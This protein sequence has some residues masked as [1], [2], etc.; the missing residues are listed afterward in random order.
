M[1]EL[2]II[3][4]IIGAGF[5]SGKEIYLFFYRFG[6]SGLMGIFVCA[7]LFSYL[8]Y[9]TL[10]IIVKNNVKSYNEF[11]NIIFKKK[12]LRETNKILINTFLL[13]SFF[14]MIAG[15]GAFLKQCFNI[16]YTIGTGIITIVCF[17][18]FL[19]DLNGLSKINSVLVP[20]LIFFVIIIGG[21]SLK[22]MEGFFN[23]NYIMMKEN[24]Y[25]NFFVQSIL[26]CSFNFILL[27]PIIVN[28]NEKLNQNNIVKITAITTLIFLVLLISIYLLLGSNNDDKIANLEMPAIYIVEVMSSKL[29]RIYEIII[30]FSIITTAVSE[31][32][33]FLKS[34]N[35][36]RKNFW[37]I[38]L[39]IC[40]SGFIVSY[41]GFGTLVE[42]LY[43][44]IGIIGLIQVAKIISIH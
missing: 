26:Y 31:G 12:F 8:L 36:S 1:L 29:K 11:L 21:V 14:V 27:I 44:A 38:A 2:I 30:L 23:I 6:L 19:N 22:E 39:C 5:A 41:L 20:V 17:I 18:I 3:G 4:S 16:N 33:G 35:I 34:L 43:P 13:I 28:F 32:M 9:K 7:V 42:I 37:K 25:N 24:L 10:L 15:F 40:I